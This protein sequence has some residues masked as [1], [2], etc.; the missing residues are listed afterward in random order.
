M[1]SFLKEHYADV[2]FSNG[3]IFVGE[4]IHCSAVICGSVCDTVLICR[5]TWVNC[6]AQYEPTTPN[7]NY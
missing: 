1:L 5:I 2:N 4:V 3:I 7:F 6:L